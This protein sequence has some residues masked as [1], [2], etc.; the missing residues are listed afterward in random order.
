VCR[1]EVGK[2][3]GVGVGLMIELEEKR[4]EQA[5]EVVRF[6]VPEVEIKESE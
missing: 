3:F 4:R 2:Y 5:A 6:V 1:I